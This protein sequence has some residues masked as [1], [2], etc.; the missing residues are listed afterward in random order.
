IEKI[1][2]IW[3]PHKYSR[4]IDNLD[5]FITCFEGA[6]ELI[7]LPVWAAGELPREINFLEDFKG[8][9]LT[10]ADR[11]H[12]LENRVTLIKDK[13]ELRVLEKGMIVSFGAGD[14][15]YQIRGIA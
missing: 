5:A 1:S 7:I 11:I 4:T 13:Q 10:M 15:T 6:A 9:N 14:I 3:Q 8:Y 2:V 12:R